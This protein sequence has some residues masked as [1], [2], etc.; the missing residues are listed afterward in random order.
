MHSEGPATGHLD[1]GFLDRLCSEAN[2]EMVF[3]QIRTAHLP[4]TS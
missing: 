3:M 4:N 2:T 1:R